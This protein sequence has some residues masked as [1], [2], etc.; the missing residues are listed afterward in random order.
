MKSLMLSSLL[1]AHG[2]TPRFRGKFRLLRLAQRLMGEVPV[3]TAWDVRMLSTPN[4]FTNSLSV[5]GAYTDVYAFLDFLKPGMCF[6][7]IG[8]NA[9]VFSLVAAQR[10]GPEGSVIAFEPS[11]PMFRRLVHNAELNGLANFFPLQVALGE[12]TEIVKFHP[13]TGAHTGIAHVGEGGTSTVIQSTYKD[14]E[15]LLS[16]LIGDRKIAVKIDVEGYELNVA[17]TLLPLLRNSHVTYLIVEV[18]HEYL[19]RSQATASELYALMNSV[20]FRADTGYSD[21][22]H[23]NELFRRD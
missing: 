2:R 23:Y 7:D 17:R 4:D 10:V 3:R 1:W 18:D 9:G 6:I 19:S 21:A 12:K 5:S 16:P 15:N 14:L 8:A 11:P 20:G 22:G 13:G